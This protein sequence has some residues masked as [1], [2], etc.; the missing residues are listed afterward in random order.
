MSTVTRW[1]MPVL[2][3]YNSAAASAA[4]PIETCVAAPTRKD[5]GR[6]G[7]APVKFSCSRALASPPRSV[8]IEASAEWERDIVFVSPRS[9]GNLY[10][11]RLYQ[12]DPLTPA[13]SPRGEG[14]GCGPGPSVED[15]S[16]V[17]SPLGEKDRMRGSSERIKWIRH[18]LRCVRNRPPAN[19][20][21]I[22]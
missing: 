3:R 22:N 1:A 10:R 4:P 8:Q 2:C 21:F 20:I 6:T 19:L 7:S 11:I 16:G 17:P 18:D 9:F 13:L 14:V 5:E 15:V 12:K